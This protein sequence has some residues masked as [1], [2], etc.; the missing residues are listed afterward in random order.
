MYITTIN[1]KSHNLKES[2]EG[3]W[4]GWRKERKAGNDGIILKK[5]KSF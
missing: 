2:K 5:I 3:I 1:E 4:G